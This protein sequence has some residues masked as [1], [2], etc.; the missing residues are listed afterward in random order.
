MDVCNNCGKFGHLYKLCK[1]PITSFGVIV[2]RIHQGQREY[3][4]IRRRDTLGFIDFMR[5][6]Y[7]VRDTFYILN[8]IK[9]MTQL[10]KENILK[11]TFEELWHFLWR[12][13]NDKYETKNL[14][15]TL[16]ENLRWKNDKCETDD[17]KPSKICN[18]ALLRSK[19]RPSLTDINAPNLQRYIDAFPFHNDFNDDNDNDNE[20]GNKEEHYSKTKFNYLKNNGILNALVETSRTFS[21]WNE[22]EWGFPKGRRNYQ[23]KDYE[24]AL[25]E[26]GE[27]TGY[28]ICYMK[29]VKNILPYEE[30]FMGSN[31]KSYKHKYYLMSMD[32]ENTT[33]TKC[34]DHS[35]VSA[36]E[37]KTYEQCI[38]IIRPYNQE[39]KRILAEIENTLNR[40]VIL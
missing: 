37:W 14:G 38:Q 21:Q 12:S 35:E 3:L 9:Q 33:N 16:G 17:I 2:F 34:F 28:P 10:E 29:N 23:E 26:M 8:M 5:G 11:M 24:C 20:K 18:D 4:M 30:I 36:M 40:V 25:R 19:E 39:K 13:K 7:N 6:K 27:E 1:V 15:E 22:P 32:Y 31:Y